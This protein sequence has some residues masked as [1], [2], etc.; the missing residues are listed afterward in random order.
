LVTGIAKDSFISIS[1]SPLT[2]I[3]IK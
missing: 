1:Y 2:I 3:H